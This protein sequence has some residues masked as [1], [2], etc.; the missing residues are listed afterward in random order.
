MLRKNS[1]IT[2]RKIS[3]VR[4]F[5][6]HNCCNQNH[7]KISEQ[8]TNFLNQYGQTTFYMVLIDAANF[9]SETYHKFMTIRKISTFGPFEVHILNFYKTFKIRIIYYPRGRTDYFFCYGNFF[10]LPSDF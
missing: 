9:H 10:A 2:I 4:V 6:V 3:V 7:S 1:L 8:L 5:M